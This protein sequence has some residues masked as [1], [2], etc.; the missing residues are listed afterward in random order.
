MHIDSAGKI[1]IGN[2]IPMWSGQYGGGLF[3]KGNNSTSDRY[4]QLCIVDSNGAIAAAGLKVNNN[5]SITCGG[6]GDVIITDGNLTVANGHGIDFASAGNASGM[7]SELLDDYEEGTFTPAIN[8]QNTTNNNAASVNAATGRYTKV[9]NL[10]SFVARLNIVVPGS[11]ATDNF[12]ITGLP[13]ASLNVSELMHIY[14]TSIS[15]VAVGTPLIFKLQ[16]NESQ[17]FLSNIQGTANGGVLLAT[18]NS[19]EIKVSGVYRA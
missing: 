16:P 18:G 13:F 5:G 12:K 2:N 15:G 10:V 11:L 6:A 1:K 9:G 17:L 3:L 19:V 4:A 8:F 14:T 7:S